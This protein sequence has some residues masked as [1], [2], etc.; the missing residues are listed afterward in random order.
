MYGFGLDMNGNY[1]PM[2]ESPPG[3]GNLLAPTAANSVVNGKIRIRCGGVCVRSVLLI[4]YALYLKINSILG[5]GFGQGATASGASL[6]AGVVR[7]HEW[8]VRRPLELWIL[9]GWRL[10]D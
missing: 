6:W 3:S 8:K 7:G 1:L 9:V 2:E 5:S 4:A 10:R